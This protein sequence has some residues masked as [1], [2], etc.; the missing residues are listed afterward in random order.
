MSNR[1]TDKAD[2][3]VNFPIGKGDWQNSGEG[4]MFVN[5]VVEQTDGHN[6]NNCCGMENIRVVFSECL[7]VPG[8][9][10][11]KTDA[12]GNDRVV[13]EEYERTLKKYFPGVW[14][15][16]YGDP[17]MA[18]KRK[19]HDAYSYLSTPYVAAITIAHTGWSGY[20]LTKRQYFHATYDDLTEEGKE[21][22]ALMEKLYPK[23]EISLL[24]WLDT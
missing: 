15:H 21:L 9:D 17:K 20:S 18:S 6:N 3:F 12:F 11:L 19:E 2:G 24:T 22:W 14:E 4:G 16:D 23:G 13:W 7:I 10:V 1:R 8:E 5:L